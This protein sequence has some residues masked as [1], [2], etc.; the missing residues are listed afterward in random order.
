M[1]VCII[2]VLPVTPIGEQGKQ[3]GKTGN[4]KVAGHGKPMAKSIWH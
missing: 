2:N 3:A 4:H 1:D